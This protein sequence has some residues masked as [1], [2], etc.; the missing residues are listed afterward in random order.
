MV[1]PE[2]PL[3]ISHLP[4]HVCPMKPT[5]RRALSALLL[6]FAINFM[7]FYDRQVVG[8]VGERLKGEWQL[9]DSQLAGLTTVFILLYGV[10]GVPLGR[11]SDTASRKR[12]LAGGIS[13][14]SMFTAL[15]GIAQS[16]GAMIVYR[17]GVGVGEASAA[18]AAT[19]LIGD[20]FS[21]KQRSR[22]ISV[23]MLGVP[24]GIGA[25]SFISGLVT[26][27]TGNWRSALFVAAVP[28]F[29][30]AALALRL[31]EPARG[32]ADPGVATESRGALE[33]I[34]MVLR[35]PTMRW[36]IASGALLNIM[37]YVL[38]AFL[39]SYF[40]R[41]H[42]LNIDIANRFSSVIFGVGG[43][44]G[45]LGGGWLCDHLAQ[46]SPRARL[47]CSAA[48]SLAIAPA[49]LIALQQ[50]QGNY[51]PF[52]VWMFFAAVALMMYYS[53][54]YATIADIVEPRSRG[55]AMSVYFFVFYLFTAAGLAGFGKL[56]D[57]RAR[58]ALGTGMDAAG[59]RANGLHDALLALPI[60]SV[61]LACVLW[62]A[63]RRVN[64]D[65][66]RI[67]GGA[68]TQPAAVVVVGG[69]QA[70]E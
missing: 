21:S 40:I 65:Y 12:I 70:A 60:V 68:R 28:G 9:T 49:L 1:T 69:L 15:S 43:T 39:T 35:I 52:A 17:L 66:A 45:M 51:W 44:I 55:T 53:S 56:S 10:I 5:N 4:H 23:F 16:F 11:L 38:P 59:A 46:R 19:S 48:S 57:I 67:R 14:W 29:I 18:P 20:L 47:R 6:L 61:T 31:P 42:G 13:L 24:L 7:N 32:A 27:A 30:L 63:S 26:Q 37:A 2:A 34:M 50:T 58:A 25:S 41:W 62:M 36:I 33:S 64:L 3:T 54:A 22:A 8:A